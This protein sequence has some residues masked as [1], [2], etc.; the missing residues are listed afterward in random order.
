MSMAV[1]R[2]SQNR[3]HDFT[4][5][6]ACVNFGS[7]R[8]YTKSYTN[9]WFSLMTG[10]FAHK[11]TSAVMFRKIN[12][13]VSEHPIVLSFVSQFCKSVPLSSGRQWQICTFH[14][15]ICKSCCS[16]SGLRRNLRLSCDE[17][18][19]CHGKI[20]PGLLLGL[21]GPSAIKMLSA[22]PQPRRS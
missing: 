19:T 17:M 10:M 15:Q 18:R 1:R 9:Q 2:I 8:S 3:F 5:C 20:C 4:I 6:C 14:G 16:S 7:S 12:T 21:R 11:S 13:S 22:K